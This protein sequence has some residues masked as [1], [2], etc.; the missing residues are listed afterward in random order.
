M[1]TNERFSFFPIKF[2]QLHEHYKTMKSLH[3]EADEIQFS[4][5]LN[6]FSK[7]NS[8]EWHFLKHVIAFFNQ[9]D[10]IINENLAINFYGEVLIPEARAF[11]GKQI[12]NETTHSETYSQLL[13]MYIQD[14]DEKAK[15]FNAIDNFPA[16]KAK[17]EW[18]MQWINK[19]DDWATRLIAFALIE[20]VFFSGSFCAVYW[21][22]ER[23]VLDALALANQYIARDEALHCQ[24]AIDLYKTMLNLHK[25]GADM[26]QYLNGVEFKPLSQEQFSE[27]LEDAVRTEKAFVCDALPVSLIGMNSEKMSQYI[28]C[29]ADFWSEKLGFKRQYK[30]E[31]PF[32]FMVQLG[33][34]TKTNFFEKKSPDYQNTLTDTE[35]ALTDD[36]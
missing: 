8:D 18:A 9:A 13:E 35:F 23:G 11:Y 29:C 15:L 16:I 2:N 26:S 4:G 20:G 19:Q 28:E 1:S 17:A 25:S 21:F 22:K 30:K 36:F 3:W 31:D 6:D 32:G 7:I 27:I 10:G 5:D 12:G 33:M 14:Q 34:E 24:F